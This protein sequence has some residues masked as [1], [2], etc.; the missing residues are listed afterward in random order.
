MMRAKW[1]AGL[2]VAALVGLAGFGRPA[3]ASNS[4]PD[5]TGEWRLDLQHSDMPQQH[6]GGGWGGHGGGS[7]GGHGGG[8]YGG[9]ASGGGGYGGGG[10]AWNHHGGGGSTTGGEAKPS[11][12]PQNRPV[13]LPNLMRVTMSPTVVSVE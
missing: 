4:R 1:I 9:H 5:F 6:G 11:G 13:R 8:G 12:E 3:R 7:W 10:D 2:G